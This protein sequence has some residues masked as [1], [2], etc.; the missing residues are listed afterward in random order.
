MK[1]IPLEHVALKSHPQINEAW[2]QDQITENPSIL[3]LGD[4]ELHD[5]ERRQTSGGRL[6]LLLQNDDQRYEV[7]LKLGSTD[8]SHIIRTIEYWNVEKKRFLQY[9]HIAVIVAEEITSLS[10]IHISEPTRPY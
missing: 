5:R 3:A 2:L 8:E 10:L 6:D 4:L 7:E 9:Q 1:L